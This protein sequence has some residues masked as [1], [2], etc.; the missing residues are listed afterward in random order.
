MNSKLSIKSFTIVQSVEMT[1]TGDNEA[2]S[3]STNER[4]LVH[5]VY[6]EDSEVEPTVHMPRIHLHH[7]ITGINFY[8]FSSLLLHNLQHLENMMQIHG[9]G[10]MFWLINYE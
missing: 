5:A 9:K 2:S 10:A 6:L 3:T 8:L 4:Y 7:H 1:G